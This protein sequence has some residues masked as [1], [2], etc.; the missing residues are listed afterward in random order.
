MEA[1][2]DS[3]SDINVVSEDDWDS[4]HELMEQGKI[5]LYEYVIKPRW[6]VTPYASL[7]PLTMIA[8]FKAWLTVN[9]AMKPKRFAKFF[10][11][12]GGL[13]S[14]V[15]RQT[16]KSMKLLALG[17]EVNSVVALPD[18]EKDEDAPFPTIP[19]ELVEFDIDQSVTPTKN[20]YYNIPAAFSKQAA[21]RIRKMERQ[22]II[23]R[24][25]RAP[26]WISGMSAVPKGLSDFRLVVNMRGPNRAINRSYF[27]LPRLDEIQRELHGSTIF[28]KLHR[29][30]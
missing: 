12:R 25:T 9:I 1:M 16:A 2:I 14:V 8:S 17:C 7:V 10:V 21:E 26:R 5:D 23:E 3:G 27:P 20:A 29:L 24:V 18:R 22:E 15:G 6:I 4:V 28:T 13:K 19:G 30:A 11:I